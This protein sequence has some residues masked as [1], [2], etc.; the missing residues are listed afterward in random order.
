[1]DKNRT[2][3]SQFYRLCETYGNYKVTK[4]EYVVNPPL[5]KAF[6][7]KRL[8]LAGRLDWE[9]CKP[10]LAFHGKHTPSPFSPLILMLS[11]KQELQKRT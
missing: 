2:A 10:I 1:M 3:E 8:E 6:E 4:V 7:K 9:D 11:F 5:V